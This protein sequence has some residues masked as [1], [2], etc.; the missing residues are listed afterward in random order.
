[1]IIKKAYF[2]NRLFLLTKYQIDFQFKITLIKI[3]EYINI[4]G[5]QNEK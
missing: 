3:K 5:C 1:M 4:K 2:F